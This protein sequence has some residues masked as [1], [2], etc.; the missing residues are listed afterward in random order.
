MTTERQR[1]QKTVE[2]LHR[3]ARNLTSLV[4]ALITVLSSAA[5]LHAQDEI[6]IPRGAAP[7]PVTIED[8]DGQ[9]VDL[10]QWIGQKPVLL[11]FW[12][13]WCENCEALLPRMRE[14]HAR[15]GDDVEFIAV[16]VGVNQ[17]PRR[18]RRHLEKHPIPFRVLWDGQGKATRAFLAPI[19]SYVVILDSAGRVVY[20]GAGPDQN[21]D[22]AIQRVLAAAT[23]AG[24]E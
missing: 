13:L 18:I 11:E 20:T 17:T 22:A 1:R 24:T 4:V 19:T 7:E 16:S 3:L 5:A 21:I 6:G 2:V 8:L 23:S 10:R 9:P 15:Y 12:A 14:A